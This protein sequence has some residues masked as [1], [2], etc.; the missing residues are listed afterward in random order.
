M[1]NIITITAITI[2]LI[3]CEKN[4]VVD[5]PAQPPKL[6]VNAL[7]NSQSIFTAKI[8]KSVAVLTASGS[9]NFKVEN[10]FAQLFEN[11]VVKDT[12]VYNP[13]TN[14]YIAKNG[15]IPAI[16]KNY[17]LKVSTVGLEAVEASTVV[18]SAISIQSIV[19]RKNVK[20]DVDGNQMDELK[21]TFTDK[22]NEHNYYL[23]KLKKPTSNTG[24]TVMYEPIYC[25]SSGDVDI[26]R[27]N[28]TPGDVNSCIDKSFLITD[29]NFNGRTKEIILF[30]KS[31]DLEVY[32]NP[33]NNLKYNAIME[34]HSI[35]AD[36][37]KY[38]RSLESYKDNEEN[39]FAE[40]APVYGNIK[41]GYGIFTIFYQTKDTIR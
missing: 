14:I 20:T 18:P 33:T 34:L 10:A 16:G 41:N 21:I 23:F 32:T 6:V 9:K 4:V 17:L 3:S 24:A 37:Y 39:P 30:I 7:V 31:Y 12:F 1:K 26:D 22:V 25:F 5:I 36:H 28:S 2:L 35:T 13:T 8:S 19:R 40:P 29:K 15:T 11:G 27:R 38:Q